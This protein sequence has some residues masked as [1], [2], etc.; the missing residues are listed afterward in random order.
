ML[1]DYVVQDWLFLESAKCH[2]SRDCLSFDTVEGL[3][4][5]QLRNSN[6]LDPSAQTSEEWYQ[7][8]A[9]MKFML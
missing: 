5:F 7:S 3:S 8:T 9:N 2:W 6:Y 1:D 4:L